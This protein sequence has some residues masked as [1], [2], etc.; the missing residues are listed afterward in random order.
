MACLGEATEVVCLGEATDIVGICDAARMLLF[1]FQV[2]MVDS[3]EMV[4]YA[5]R[6]GL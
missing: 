5:K 1:F 3:A 2:R 6:L 4:L